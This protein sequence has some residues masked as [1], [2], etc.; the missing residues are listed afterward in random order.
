MKKKIIIIGTVLAAIVVGIIAFFEVSAMIQEGKLKVEMKEID[1]LANE[2]D[3]DFDE[4]NKRLDQRVA[5]GSYKEVEDAYKTYLKDALASILEIVDIVEDERLTTI[6]SADNY[7]SDGPNF[8]K[9][10]EYIVT[11]KERVEV[12]KAEYNEF[13]TEEKMM[14]YIDKK[15]LGNRY[16][17]FYKDYVIGD[18]SDLEKEDS[19]V[20][21]LNELIELLD[22]SEEI[23]DFLKANSSSWYIEGGNIYFTSDSALSKYNDLITKLQEI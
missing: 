19:L 1:D 23:V 9:T 3:I 4:L 20:T 15:E 11:T 12:A 10:K 22:I 21:S 7:K 18:L 17:N 8:V 6:L 5:S 14:S 2:K 13:L 16:V